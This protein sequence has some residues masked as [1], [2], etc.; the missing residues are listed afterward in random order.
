MKKFTYLLFLLNITLCF[1]EEKRIYP[2][3]SHKSLNEVLKD[4]KWKVFNK[5]EGFFNSDK[6]KDVALILQ[7]KDSILETRIEENPRKNI[8][9]ILL[10]FIN[11]KVFI[12]NN[13][14]IPR[15]DEGGMNYVVPEVSIQNKKLKIYIEYLRSNI[16][17]IFEY[18]KND[19]AL[20]K[21]VSN[22]VQSATGNYEFLKYDF[23]K[24]IL[25]IETGNISK[26]GEKV[27]KIPIKLKNGLKKLSQFKKMYH[28]EVLE[29]RY[30]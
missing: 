22:Y 8:A 18:Q 3:F 1:S 17:Y 16:S 25:H 27:K 20:V 6:T 14:F 21:A 15:E 10:I 29:D 24:R 19:L 9:R 5:T 26:D 13:T 30:L 12:Q 2:D 23:K 7:S 11:D 28:W 4:S